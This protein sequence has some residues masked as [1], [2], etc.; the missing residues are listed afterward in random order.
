M[1][2]LAVHFD[3]SPP[4]FVQAPA[5]GRDSTRIKWYLSL[6]LFN[7]LKLAKLIGVRP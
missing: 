6:A 5:R 4:W 2:P 7:N 1:I 3:V